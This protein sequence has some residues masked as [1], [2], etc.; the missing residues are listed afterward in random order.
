MKKAA[1]RFNVNRLFI[2][3]AGASRRA[4]TDAHKAPL[5][6]EFCQEITDLH[7]SRPSWVSASRDIICTKWS[8][9]TYFEQMGLEE[10][11]LRQIS[12]FE[13]LNAIHPRRRPTSINGPEYLNHIAHLIM[14]ILCRAKENSEKLYQTFAEKVFPAADASSINDRIIT[15]NYDDLLDK[16]LIDKYTLQEVYFDRMKEHQLVPLLFRRHQIFDPP[17][18]IKLHGSVNWRCNTDDFHKIIDKDY[19]LTSSDQFIDIWYSQG[20]Q[21][22]PSDSISPFIVPPL[23][24]KPITE[25]G[26][27]R[28]LW[29]KAYEYLYEAKE[30]VICG[31]SL[32]NTD[33]L[34]YSMFSNFKNKS[35]KK[36]TIVDIDPQI[37]GKWQA[38]LYRNNIQIEEWR[39][40]PGF[41]EY[42]DRL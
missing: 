24:S 26:I 40:F 42:V 32:P 22:S 5:D 17:L 10:A 34:A 2:L 18:L 31:Y 25:F 9:P 12:H 28:Y 21:P 13:F 39:W 14:F 29:T 6:K 15:F 37:L 20:A 16:Y 27:L 33:Q 3:G 11:V 36:V 38:L 7:T 23:P 8:Y 19:R 41:G 30:L 4:S 35:I 1:N